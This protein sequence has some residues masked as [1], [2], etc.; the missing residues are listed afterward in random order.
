MYFIGDKQIKCQQRTNSRINRDNNSCNLFIYTEMHRIISFIY[1]P[2]QLHS[3]LLILW[4]FFGKKCFFAPAL[5]S[6][7]TNFGFKT[8]IQLIP[9]YRKKSPISLESFGRRLWYIVHFTWKCSG[10]KGAINYSNDLWLH[11][12]GRLPPHEASNQSSAICPR[13]FIAQIN[14]FDGR[15]AAEL[16]CRKCLKR[17][18]NFPLIS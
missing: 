11:Y 9:I 8:A 15:N 17:K 4:N 6:I 2:D 5:I 10:N 3:I 13:R 18:V 14:D 12:K 1:F 7:R 16:N